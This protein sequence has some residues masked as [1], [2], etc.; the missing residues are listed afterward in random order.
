M[1]NK[2]RK[3][4]HRKNSFNLLNQTKES[5]FDYGEVY[6][7][8][9]TNI[10]FSTVDKEISSIA[11][12]STQPY[13]SKT[14]TALNLAI[15]FAAKYE[16]VLIIDCDLRKPR[17]HQYLNISNQTGLTNALM[18]YSKSNKINQDCFKKI[19]DKSF[20]GYLAVLTAGI[21]VPN[22]NEILSSNT[23][24][25]FI[26]ELKKSFDFIIIDCPPISVVSDAVP[27]GHAVDGTLF[28]CSCQDTNRKDA[29]NALDMLKQ[30]NVNV[31]GTVLTKADTYHRGYGYGY[32]YGYKY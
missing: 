5:Q 13:E 7:N 8:I 20:A 16:K 4:Q 6:R 10:E 9:R 2:K 22:P 15:I 28:I 17:L 25:N 32:G 14:T 31:I 12:T 29:Q 21:K 23:F 26:S 1:F 24:M 19:T 30:S 3:K 27:I 18:D 11:I